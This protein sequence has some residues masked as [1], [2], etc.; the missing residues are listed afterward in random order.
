MVM[1]LNALEQSVGKAVHLTLK[2][3]HVI[4]GT[5]AGFDE[6]MN[7]VVDKAEVRAGSQTRK[8]GTIVLRGTNVVSI[9]FK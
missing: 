7:L 6:H 2:D 5:L 3:G 1:P 4:E 8:A 9:S